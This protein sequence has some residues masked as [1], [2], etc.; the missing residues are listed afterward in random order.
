MVR[1][2]T[3]SKFKKVKKI[4]LPFRVRKWFAPVDKPEYTIPPLLEKY[5]LATTPGLIAS[6]LR[7]A[8]DGVVS[9][10]GFW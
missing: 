8:G 10:A 5:L 6:I 7:N 3:A 9:G 2:M 4:R 1:N